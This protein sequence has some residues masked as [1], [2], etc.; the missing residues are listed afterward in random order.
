M[1]RVHAYSQLIRLPNVFTALADICLGLVT[2]SAL[3]ESMPSGRWWLAGRLSSGGFSVPLQRWN[4]LE[5][6]VRLGAGPARAAI[7]SSSERE[8]YHY[9]G[10][11]RG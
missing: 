4:G 1:S 11:T 7:P 10:S 8:N 6:L 9:H 3:A 5:R 2:A